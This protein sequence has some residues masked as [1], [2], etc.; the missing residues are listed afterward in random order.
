MRLS[1]GVLYAGLASAIL[2]AVSASAN[3]ASVL[4]DTGT[5]TV[6]V[7]GTS[8][9]AT[10][11]S[12]SAIINT[13]N[14]S[15]VSGLTLGLAENVLGSG[16]TI[17][18]GTGTKQISDGSGDVVTLELR[19]LGGSYTAGGLITVTSQ[20]T[21]VTGSAS[22]GGFNFYTLDFGSSTTTINDPSENWT[23]I[24]GVNGSGPVTTAFGIQETVV[25]EPSTMALLGIG[26]TGFL[27]F[28]R[29]FKRHAAA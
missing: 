27:A 21:S 12:T 20:I 26:M 13:V 17:T 7:N 18:G 22:V 24:F 15:A 2:F 14:G 19:F 23:T 29:F 3:A 8:G 9:G 5:G 11:V 1:K 28:R 4:T 16:G 10:I 6:A 25:P